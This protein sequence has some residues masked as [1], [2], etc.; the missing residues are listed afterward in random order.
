MEITITEDQQEGGQTEVGAEVEAEAEAEVG[1]ED[2]PSTT[3]MILRYM[4]SR[5]VSR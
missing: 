5:A 4:I 3:L 2:N 1:A